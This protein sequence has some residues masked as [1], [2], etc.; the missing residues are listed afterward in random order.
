M[1][2]VARIRRILPI[3]ILTLGFATFSGGWWHVDTHA[4]G[5][6]RDRDAY[7]PFRW[8]NESDASAHRGIGIIIGFGWLAALAAWGTVL[9]TANRYPRQPL[10][11]SWWALGAL[12]AGVVILG[13]AFM[14]YPAEAGRRL[15]TPTDWRGTT[16]QTTL[17]VELCRSTGPGWSWWVALV[18]G[19]VAPL[20]YL[21]L[22]VRLGAPR[23]ATSRAPT[24][25]APEAARAHP[26]RDPAPKQP[27]AQD[28]RARCSACGAALRKPP[29]QVR[30]TCYRCGLEN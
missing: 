28:N 21:L 23:T 6:L 30:V 18:A 19:V 2:P 12:G 7:G 15:G 24:S 3:L 25:Q 27:T 26:R 16:C 10:K 13:Y 22:P 14:A 5:Q 29:G 17:G 20:V 1:D 11:A 8:G 9:V 4:D